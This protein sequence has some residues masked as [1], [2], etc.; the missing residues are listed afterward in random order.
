[1]NWP[2]QSES[3]VASV[4]SGIA[5]YQSNKVKNLVL[6]DGEFS[7]DIGAELWYRFYEL[8]GCIPFIAGRDGVKKYDL[9]WVEEKRRKGYSYGSNYASKVLKAAPQYGEKLAQN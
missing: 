3:V 5:W 4:T 7:R 2:E 9:T 8:N 6:H 1:M